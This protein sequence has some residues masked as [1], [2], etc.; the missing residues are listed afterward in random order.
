MIFFSIQHQEW[1]VFLDRGNLRACLFVN[2]FV[3]NCNNLIDMWL[4]SGQVLSLGT[5]LTI[6]GP[7][8]VILVCHLARIWTAVYIGGLI[9][10]WAPYTL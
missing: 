2:S 6:A 4:V 7:G 8:L 1:M 9:S 10:I 5:T 3:I